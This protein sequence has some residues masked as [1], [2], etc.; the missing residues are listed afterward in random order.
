MIANGN[1]SS[2]TRSVFIMH[3]NDSLS[4]LR[5]SSAIY[6]LTQNTITKS[7]AAEGACSVRR[8]SVHSQVRLRVQHVARF[9]RTRKS[10][11]LSLQL[12]NKILPDYYRGKWKPLYILV[13]FEFHYAHRRWRPHTKVP[14]A[15]RGEGCARRASHGAARGESFR[16]TDYSMG[17]A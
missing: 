2:V 17:A 14:T 3:G 4:Y 7:I 11:L 15:R 13:Y 12:H 6:W 16:I 1:T 9:H 8:G 5:V 10:P